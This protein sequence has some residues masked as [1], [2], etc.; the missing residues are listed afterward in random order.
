MHECEGEDSIL[1][2]EK[3]MDELFGKKKHDD[4]NKK[5]EKEV[6]ETKETATNKKEQ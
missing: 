5:G 1:G 2:D 4:D 3:D 6:A